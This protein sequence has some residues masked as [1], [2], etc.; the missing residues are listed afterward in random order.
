MMSEL[1]KTQEIER[2]RR[3]VEELEG[4]IRLLEMSG[5]PVRV[6][7]LHITTSGADEYG[8]MRPPAWE[9]QL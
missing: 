4:R 9:H 1:K 7:G 3:K 8:I 5:Q 6:A 2:L